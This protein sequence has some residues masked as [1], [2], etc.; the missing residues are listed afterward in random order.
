[1]CE[2]KLLLRKYPQWRTNC[3]VETPYTDSRSRGLRFRLWESQI[4]VPLGSRWPFYVN[5]IIFHLA[6]CTD[7]PREVQFAIAVTRITSSWH[8]AYFLNSAIRNFM[9]PFGF[10]W[11]GIQCSP[12]SM[13]QRA[14][15]WGRADFSIAN[16]HSLFTKGRIMVYQMLVKVYACSVPWI[17]GAD[18]LWTV[19]SF[20]TWGTVFGIQH[21]AAA[22]AI[23]RRDGS[24]SSTT[25]RNCHM[26]RWRS[27]AFS[28][29]WVLSIAFFLWS[30][31]SKTMKRV[32]RSLKSSRLTISWT[33][34]LIFE[35]NARQKI[36]KLKKSCRES[37]SKFF[38]KF[39]CSF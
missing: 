9:L 21:S 29:L 25:F 32:S 17:P 38:S 7:I 2:V 5:T 31:N 14:G 13:A 35:R 36:M 33:E 16:P 11:I 24:L 37:P 3:A 27:G 34:K 12:L 19:L 1:M 20:S 30:W 39:F 22:M 4:I 15:R 28:W 23:V 8:I 6:T 10:I 26:G 18:V